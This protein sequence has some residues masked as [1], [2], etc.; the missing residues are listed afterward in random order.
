[1]KDVKNGVANYRNCTIN[2]VIREHQGKYVAHAQIRELISDNIETVWSDEENPY[3]S[4]G[5]AEVG[6]IQSA[7]KIIDELIDNK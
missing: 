7:K 6:I 2:Y 5:E 1:M 3:A 4:Q